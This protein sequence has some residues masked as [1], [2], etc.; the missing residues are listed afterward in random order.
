MPED[1]T[2]QNM[3]I[4]RRL[5][6]FCDSG[7]NDFEIVERCV[8]PQ[9]WARDWLGRTNDLA[10]EATQIDLSR[11][12]LEGLRKRFCLF[13]ITSLS[14]VKEKINRVIEGISAKT[15]EKLWK[16]MI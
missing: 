14:H 10:F 9:I 16:N 11:F 3:E 5:K 6:M 8:T 7:P 1:G 12:L 13:W 2:I 15:L 4:Q